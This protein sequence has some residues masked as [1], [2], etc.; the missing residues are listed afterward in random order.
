MGVGHGRGT[1]R[2]RCG[3]E[4]ELWLRTVTVKRDSNIWRSPKMWLK[5]TAI[6]AGVWMIAFLFTKS[7]GI[8]TAIAV[9]YLMVGFAGLLY[10]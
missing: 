4:F 5:T 10:T 2:S 3:F 9:I 1:R 8:A 7:V 6:L